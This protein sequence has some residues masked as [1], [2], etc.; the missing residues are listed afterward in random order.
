MIAAL[1]KGLPFSH[2]SHG[3]QG[4]QQKTC[5]NVNTAHSDGHQALLSLLSN[6]EFGMW[7]SEFAISKSQPAEL[8]LPKIHLTS[9]KITRFKWTLTDIVSANYYKG[10]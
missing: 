2:E 3:G 6:L 9:T 10:K 4:S 1:D 7:Q 8:S 5:V